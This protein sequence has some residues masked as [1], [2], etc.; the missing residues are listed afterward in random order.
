MSRFLREFIIDGYNL[1]HAL[2]L[3]QPGLT[4]E[5]Q[6]AHLEAYLIEAQEKK[7]CKITIVYDGRNRGKALRDAGALN[8]VFTAS[9]VT[10]DEWIIDLLRSSPKQARQLTV[11]SSDTLITSHASAYGAKRMSSETFADRYL[12]ECRGSGKKHA[13]S[14]HAGKSADRRLSDREVNAWM[15]LFGEENDGKGSA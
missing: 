7:R 15:K 3:Q 1:L 5:E 8:R 12:E 2:G 9:Q 6:R 14:E 13:R 10:A 11:V 4:L